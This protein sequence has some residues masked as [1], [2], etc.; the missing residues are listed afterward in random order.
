MR[1]IFAWMVCCLCMILFVLTIVVWVR[2]FS[3]REGI[4]HHAMI[5][6]NQVERSTYIYWF[7]GQIH[8]GA[9]TY[10]VR[11]WDY[12]PEKLTFRTSPQYRA[13]D[14]QNLRQAYGHGAVGFYWLR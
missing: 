13:L 12:E 9:D 2:S 4:Y 8:F 3:E 7:R 6:Q 11:I 1:R 14:E 10:N 5:G